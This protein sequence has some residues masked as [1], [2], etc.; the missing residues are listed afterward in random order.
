MAFDFDAFI[1]K[2]CVGEKDID[3]NVSVGIFGRNISYIPAGTGFESF[4]I[5]GDFHKSYE[6]VRPD[7]MS[8]PSIT[9]EKIVVFIRKIDM[10]E[11]YPKPQQGDYVEVECFRFQVIDV[12]IH[13]PGSLKLV[14]HEEL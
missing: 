7:T 13:I 8:E 2:A 4:P 12:Q 3:G 10:P 6:E 5:A 1:N 11:A 14:L 9:S